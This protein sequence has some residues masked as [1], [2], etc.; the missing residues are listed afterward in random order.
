MEKT[1]ITRRELFAKSLKTAA[2]IGMLGLAGSS[3]ADR[4]F[5]QTKGAEEV[6]SF[7][8]QAVCELTCLQTIGPC[9]S[10]NPLVRQDITSGKTG[11]PIK[12]GFRVVDT[13][14]TPIPN[15]TV[16]IW[17]TDTGGIYSALSGFCA[18]NDPTA[19]TQNFFRGVQPTDADGWAYFD[20]MYPGWYPSR[21][22]H[23]HATFRIGTTAMATTQF[24][25]LDRMNRF[26]YR[27]HPLY[28]SRP[29]AATINTTDNILGGSMAR[30]MPYV[31][32]TKFQT[33]RAQMRVWKTVV[34][35]TTPT[36]CNA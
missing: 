32:S 25:F 24:Y 5:S 11:L 34:I 20:T 27:N 30:M 8:P 10:A 13:N 17:H 22:T 7:D 23:I 26:V 4:V 2:G 31:F 16:D 36:T 9:Y 3:V 15:A 6:L 18:N 1:I 12:L 19:P 14:C 21:T 28:N 29:V 35:N 33:A